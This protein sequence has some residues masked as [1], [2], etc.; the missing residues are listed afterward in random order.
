MYHPEKCCQGVDGE[1]DLIIKNLSIWTT[2]RNVGITK[3][4]LIED[5]QRIFSERKV[6]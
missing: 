5:V 1:G 4:G 3:N 6:T 2:A